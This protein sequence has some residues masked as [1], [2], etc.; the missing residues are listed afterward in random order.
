MFDALITLYK[1]TLET[2][3][4]SKKNSTKPLSILLTKI[5]TAVKERYQ[6]YCATAYARSG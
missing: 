3:I 5:L 4:H 2:K 1:N 6:M